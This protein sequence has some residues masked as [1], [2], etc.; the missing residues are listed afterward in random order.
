MPTG[1]VSL[2]NS[3]LS[4]V[5]GTAFVDFSA[6]GTLTPYL[7]G[8][9]TLTDSAGKKAIGYIKSAGT[10]ETLGE[11]L[12][13]NGS[14][15]AWTGDT[16]DG[17]TYFNHLDGTRYVEE[18]PAGQCHFVDT[19]K[20]N[21]SIQTGTNVQGA[22]YKGSIDV[23]AVV[24]DGI[25]FGPVPA[26]SAEVPM[27][28]TTGVKTYYGAASSAV[29]RAFYVSRYGVAAGDVTFDDISFKQVLTPSAT[30][31]TITSTPGGTTYNWASV[32]SGFSYNDPSGYTYSIS[33]VGRSIAAQMSIRRRRRLHG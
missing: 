3:R 12:I 11:E 23:K 8:K 18:S 32:E 33:R 17:W 28:T 22:L 5:N 27:I 16:P 25:Y 1:S 31:V 30:G 9:L 24:S 10:G 20:A 14:F 7:G 29:N 21:F 13:T 2:A 4:L 19:D 26:N 6:A 15:T